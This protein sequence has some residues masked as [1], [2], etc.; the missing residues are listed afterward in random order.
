MI[1][2]YFTDIT[3]LK[4]FHQIERVNKDKIFSYEI[5]WFLKRKPIQVL[6]NDREELVYVNEKFILGILVNHL[7]EGKIDDFS[8]NNI[9]VS[10]CDILLYY[11][12]YRDCE[13]K[14]LE[15]LIMSFKA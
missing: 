8:G 4:E 12:K 2:D 14:V 7:T 11:L 1:L 13:P 15:M 10:F 5:S 3:R 9:L 6:K